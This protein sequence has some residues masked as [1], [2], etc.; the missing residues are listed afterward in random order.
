[1]TRTPG[2]H[3]G[4]SLPRVLDRF[5]RAQSAERDLSANTLAAYE[6]DLRQFAEWCARARAS[7]VG[8]LDRRL[9]RRYVAWL[10]ESNYARRTIARKVS[11]IRALLRWAVLHDVISEDP[12]RDLPTPRLGRPL[13]KALKAKDVARL[14]ELP[15]GDDSVGLRDRAVIELLYGSGLR[16]AELCALD[17]DDVEGGG[18]SL[19]VRGKGRKERVVPVGDRAGAALGAYLDGP[20]RELALRGKKA[21]PALFLNS[22]GSRLGPRSVRTLVD[23]YARTD[24]M[25][26]V[27]PHALRHSFATHLLDGGADLRVVQELLGH[28]NLATTQIYTHVSAERLRAVYERSHPRA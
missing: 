3:G 9:L 5:L 18:A 4:G 27:S 22:R 2:S 24:G 14:C 28:E 13:P 16:V 20:R 11:A 15:P 17:L 21:V 25:P 6:R 19:R 10:S 8:D 26:H 23:R 12:S 1:M 7:V